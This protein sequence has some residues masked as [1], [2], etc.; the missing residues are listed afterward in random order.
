MP[1]LWSGR[2]LEAGTTPHWHPYPEIDWIVA[3]IYPWPFNTTPESRPLTQYHMLWCFYY[4]GSFIWTR[5]S[6][7]IGEMLGPYKIWQ[8]RICFREA[9]KTCHHQIGYR[10]QHMPKFVAVWYLIKASMAWL[11]GWLVDWSLLAS[12]IYSSPMEFLVISLWWSMIFCSCALRIL[13]SRC[14]II[15][16]FS[17]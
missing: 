14:S 2:A 8:R 13:A 1:T 7:E 4:L 15:P 5:Y 6:F 16:M 11:A 12:T 17:F 9:G 3:H 10:Q